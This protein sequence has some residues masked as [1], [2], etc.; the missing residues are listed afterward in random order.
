MLGY[1]YKLYNTVDDKYY[2]GSTIGKLSDRKHRHFKDSKT[3]KT[4]LYE[5]MHKLNNKL[6]W[7]IEKI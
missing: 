6:V 1:I 2:I 7:R 4:N 3:R 5:H